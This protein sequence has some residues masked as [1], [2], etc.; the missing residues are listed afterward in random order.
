MKLRVLTLNLHK[1]FSSLNGRFVLNEMR[2][3]I[4]SVNADI[5]FLQEVHGEQPEHKKLHSISERASQVEY[6]ADEIWPQYSYGKNSATSRGD[7]GNAC[8][9]RN[10]TQRNAT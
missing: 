1:G 10:I 8:Q 4:R 7:H 6:L 9:V 2:D 3:A 5:V